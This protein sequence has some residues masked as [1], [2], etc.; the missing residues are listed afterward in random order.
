VDGL[1]DHVAV[2]TGG[3]TGIGRAAAEALADAGCRVALVGR[4]PEPLEETAEALDARGV[5]C[6]VLRG[7]VS[8]PAPTRALVDQVQQAWGRLDVLVNNA[9]LNVPRRALQDVSAEDWD[10]VLQVNL[11]GTFLM[12]QAALPV[13]REQRA[14]TVINVSSIAGYRPSRLT[15]PAYSAAKA[16]V[17]AFTESVNLTERVHG[18]RACA[19]CPGEVATPILDRRPQPPS[20]E[21]RAAMLQPEDLAQTILLV[22]SLPQRATIE[23]LTIVPTDVGDFR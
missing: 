12:T 7:D 18:I 15:G 16:G 4:R 14:G 6:L 13:M 22:A 9:G 2:V 17:I 5:D 10:T 20:A 11:T 8:D 21:A 1:R 19:I 3:G 23:L